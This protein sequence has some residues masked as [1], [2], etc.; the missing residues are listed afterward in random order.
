MITNFEEIT[1]ELSPDELELIPILI[2]GLKTKTK[3]FKVKAPEIVHGMRN[4]ISSM[5]L[6]TKMTEARLRKCINYIRSNSLL[7]VIATS[8]GYYVSYDK[9]EIENQ[10]LSLTERSRSIMNCAE[11]L[12]KLL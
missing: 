6:K 5:G 4:K 7:P 9:N 10:I 11:G 1:E 3:A 8:K 12:K 2:S